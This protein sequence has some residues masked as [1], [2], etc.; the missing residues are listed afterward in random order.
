MLRYQAI[1][2]SRSVLRLVE[3]TPEASLRR[4]WER[5]PGRWSPE[6]L[7]AATRVQGIFDDF[8][9]AECVDILDRIERAR[10][11]MRR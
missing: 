4:A 2:D 11:V 10:L 1:E 6:T 7:V 5:W 3:D 8:S 9:T